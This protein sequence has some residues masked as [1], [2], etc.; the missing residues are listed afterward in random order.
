MKI[1]F[2][3]TEGGIDRNRYRVLSKLNIEQV[4]EH[5]V[6]EP[7]CT[8]EE[9]KR[10]IKEDIKEKTE[11]GYQFVKT[12]NHM[13]QPIEMYHPTIILVDSISKIITDKVEDIKNDTTNAMYMQV[14]GNR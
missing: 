5:I 13:G 14:A 6:F 4:D 11:K 12:V 10:C 8:I 3:D 9:I 7:I 1:H 2:F